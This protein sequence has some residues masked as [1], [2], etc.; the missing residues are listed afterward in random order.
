MSKEEIKT[1]QDQFENIDDEGGVKRNLKDFNLKLVAGIAICW[2][3]FQLW[4]ASPFPFLLNFGIF[5]DLPA[6]AIHLAFALILCFLIY[7]SKKSNSNQP[8]K[9]YDYLLVGLSIITTFYIVFDY[10]GLVN[11][12]G[13]LAN[14]NL[15]GIKIPYEMILGAIGMILLLEATRRAIGLPLV[16]I[17]VIFIIFSIFGQQMPDLIAHAGLS[18]TRLVGYHWLG[19]RLTKVE[20]SDRPAELF[21]KIWKSWE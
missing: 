4:Y 12:Q 13:V 18:I 5:I 14:I 10:E 21:I 9:Y 11:R 7:P 2:T 1:A 16:F 8:I 3:L 19:G 6:R 15:F 20:T 17:A